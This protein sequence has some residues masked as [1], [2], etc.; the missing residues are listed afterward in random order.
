[1][2]ILVEPTTLVFLRTKWVNIHSHLEQSLY[3]GEHY[4]GASCYFCKRNRKRV[5]L[6]ARLPSLLSQGHDVYKAL[7]HVTTN[8]VLTASVCYRQCWYYYS[9]KM[10]KRGQGHKWL[11]KWR[12][13]VLARAQAFCLSLAVIPLHQIAS[14]LIS[15][16]AIQLG[17]SSFRTNLNKWLIWF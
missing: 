16:L 3:I 10:R 9:Q 6:F 5:S 8:L 1:M 14:F 2:G 12:K 11:S 15:T 7:S 4:R 13:R 17:S